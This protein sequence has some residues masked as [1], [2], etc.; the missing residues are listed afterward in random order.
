MIGQLAISGSGTFGTVATPTKSTAIVPR[1]TQAFESLN[2]RLR[3]AGSPTDTVLI[4][5]QTDS[6]GAPSGVSIFTAPPIDL[7]SMSQALSGNPY[8]FDLNGL[9]LTAGTRYWLVFERSGALDN[10]NAPVVFSNSGTPY[11]SI[12]SSTSSPQMQ[13]WLGPKPPLIVSSLA[14]VVTT[15]SVLTEAAVRRAQ[16]QIRPRSL[17]IPPATLAQPS[18]VAAPLVDVTFAAQSRRNTD[19][20]RSQNFYKLY[21]PAVVNVPAAVVT[22]ILTPRTIAIHLAK[23]QRRTMPYA[24]LGPPVAASS[25]VFSGPEVVLAKRT[26]PPKVESVLLPQAVTSSTFVAP[27]LAVYCLQPDRLARR[28]RRQLPATSLAPPTVLQTFAAGKPSLVTTRPRPTDKS[29]HAPTVI[30]TPSVEQR[31]QTISVALSHIRPPRTHSLLSPPAVVTVATFIA[32]PLDVLLVARDTRISMRR[33]FPLPGW[34]GDSG[35]GPTAPGR[36]PN[37]I[38]AAG[39]LSYWRLGEAVGAGT[40]VDQIGGNNGTYGGTVTLGQPGLVTGDPETAAGFGAANA[41]VAVPTPLLAGQSTWTFECLF[42][43]PIS[44]STRVLYEEAGTTNDLVSIRI[45]SG[46]LSMVFRDDAGVTNNVSLE[47]AT[48]RLDDGGIHHIVVT[49]NGTAVQGI[50]DGTKVGN[51]TIGSGAQTET[52]TATIGRTASGPNGS[53]QEVAIYRRQILPPEALQHYLA[54]V[55]GA[56]GQVVYLRRNLG[57]K[58]PLITASAPLSLETLVVKTAAITRRNTETRRRPHWLLAGPTTLAQPPPTGYPVAVTLARTRARRATVSAIRPPV[59]LATFATGHVALVTIRPRPTTT[60]L[61]PPIVVR[62]PSVEQREQ[63]IAVTLVRTR[64]RRTASD[65]PLVVFATQSPVETV[66]FVALVRARPRP[67]SKRLAPPTALQVFQA[68]RPTLAR[69]RPRRT[70]AALHPPTV[71]RVPSVEAREQTISVSLVRTRPRHTIS[72]VRQ[73]TA[74][75]IFA[76]G[77]PS[78][79]Q[80]RPRPTRHTVVPPSVVR[81]PSVEQ[82]ENTI[83]VALVRSRPRATT[84][85]LFEPT[86]LQAFFG[87]TVALTRVRPRHTMTALYEP[88]VVRVPSVEQQEDTIRVTLVRARPRPTVKALFQPTALQTFPAGKPALVR[89]RPRP[90]AKLLA[91][92]TTL[93]TFA[94]PLTKLV[95][96]RPRPTDYRISAPTVL[97]VPSV[98]QAEQTIR[99]ALDRTRP[100]P[101]IHVLG[102]PTVVRVP[103]VEQREQTITTKL[104]TTRPRPTTKKLA[105]PTKIIVNPPVVTT[106]LV[107]TVAVRT[108]IEQRRHVV[109]HFLRPPTAVIPL[110]TLRAQTITVKTVRTRPRPTARR[111]Y[112]PTVLQ[113]FPAAVTPLVRARPRPTRYFLGEPTVVRVPAVEQAL[114]TIRVTLVETRPRPK[115]AILRPPVRYDATS[116]ISATTVRTRPRPTTSFLSPPTTLAEFFGPVEVEVAVKIPVEQPRRPLRYRLSPPIFR[117]PTETRIRVSLVHTR[118]RPTVKRLRPPTVLATFETPPLVSFAPARRPATIAML[119]PP[120]AVAVEAPPKN[121]TLAPARRPETRSRLAAPAVVAA[122]PIPAS[123]TLTPSRRPAFVSRLSPPSVIEPPP[124]PVAVYERVILVAASTRQRFRLGRHALPPVLP[125]PGLAKLPANTGYAVPATTSDGESIPGATSDGHT[126]PGAASDGRSIPVAESDGKAVPG[127]A[128]T[129]GLT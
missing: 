90:T 29:L 120:T 25:Q 65:L 59:V 78:L 46:L 67:T 123:I 85:A 125:P 26:R 111:L 20:R 2:I 117:A 23:R 105:P 22:S 40:A 91:P 37:T 53:M 106:I 14:P 97:R 50:I 32:P 43:G 52:I 114:R 70:V 18:P 54:A 15:I 21:S 129:E 82:Q 89:A 98:E 27:P 121:L 116:T 84:R 104:V 83:R 100:R 93:A 39:P 74:L 13:R 71:V 11:W 1:I 47:S 66:P 38:L 80:T 113:T 57:P 119:A 73:P 124:P 109:G 99:A 33:R 61:S 24:I 56:P 6:G 55:A 31:Q 28:H 17:L 62:T 48:A 88:T 72:A 9:V 58:P 64:P 36:Y 115:A 110:P 35:A 76:A 16:T 77:K 4:S 44:A 112:K 81:V 94:G 103:S 5:I 3:K 86:V 75:Q 128:T 79:V 45:G 30:R 95:R 42:R 108:R 7:T 127:T 126:V 12:W 60:L 102:K 19:G 8:T 10:S 63:T 118:P 51:N 87:P 41:N 49:R 92:P 68:G 101:T 69:I 96:V 122:P 107:R 34:D